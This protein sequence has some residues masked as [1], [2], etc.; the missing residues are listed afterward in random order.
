MMKSF[1]FALVLVAGLSGCLKGSEGTE[2]NCNYDACAFVAPTSEIQSVQTYLTDNNITATQ[3]CSGAFYI[4]D[5]AGTGATPNIC[6]F[7]NASYVGKLTNGTVFDQG[8]FQQPLQLGKLVRGWINT[9]PLIKQGG[10]IRLFLPPSLGYG[11]Q[12]NG[13]I[14]ANS[15]LI[16]DLELTFVQ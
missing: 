6:S 15:I 16:F 12:A 1:L 10:K 11:S 3:H 5:V 9:I 2:E 8:T 14:P 7:I 13:P 4:I